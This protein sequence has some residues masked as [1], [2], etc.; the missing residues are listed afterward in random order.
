MK[1]QQTPEDKLIDI[2]DSPILEDE[3]D[4]Y[5][6][7]KTGLAVAGEINIGRNGNPVTI[8]VEDEETG[9][10]LELNHISSAFLMIEDKRKT[11]SGWLSIAVGNVERVSEVLEF[12]TRTTLDGLKKITGR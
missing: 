8:V 7:N 3:S 10:V 11:T 12:L 1:K 4:L 5:F 6:G 2:F 9:E